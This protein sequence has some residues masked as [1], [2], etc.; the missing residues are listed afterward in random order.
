MGT[1]VVFS[2]T[3]DSS[4]KVCVR[5]STRPKGPPDDDDGS[6]GSYDDEE[7]ED[8]EDGDDDDE[9]GDDE[10]EDEDDSIECRIS[11]S[12]HQKGV[13]LVVARATEDGFSVT[14]ISHSRDTSIGAER[15]VAE[16]WNNR[17]IYF[18]TPQE[19]EDDVR[20]S[21]DLY[22]KDRGLD[23]AF[24]SSIT[25]SMRNGTTMSSPF[26]AITKPSYLM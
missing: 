18:E 22:L 17:D 25:Q 12:K 7:D 11:F 23:S 1:A 5:F 20:Q 10:E 9:D 13:L 8:D 24:A 6:E 3:Y 4:E 26:C 19:L 21:L 16:D 2:R 14:S 15:P